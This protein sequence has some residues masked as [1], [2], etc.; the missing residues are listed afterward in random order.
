VGDKSNPHTAI[1]EILADII[2]FDGLGGK[3]EAVRFDRN[4]TDLAK[5][6]FKP[7][8]GAFT[9]PKQIKVACGAIRTP[10]P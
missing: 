6:V 7:L 10:A 2:P 1:L 8:D 3:T 4:T 5:D 9:T